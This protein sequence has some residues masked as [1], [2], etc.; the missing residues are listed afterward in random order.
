MSH[1]VFALLLCYST[2]LAL[3]LALLPSAVAAGAMQRPFAGLQQSYLVARSRLHR[4]SRD[5]LSIENN[6]EEDN[7][8]RSSS[9]GMYIAILANA[10]VTSD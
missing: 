7:R 2:P 6:R 5:V 10:M 4:P 3:L 8:G 1:S 9:N